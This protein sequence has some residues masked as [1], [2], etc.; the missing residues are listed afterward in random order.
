MTIDNGTNLDGL[1]SAW[2][3]LLIPNTVEA[4]ILIQVRIIFRLLRVE[5]FL[6][7]SRSVKIDPTVEAIGPTH[8]AV[9][10]DDALG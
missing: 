8:A 10:K 3:P 9:S 2:E 4:P 1:F 5:L 6:L 7:F